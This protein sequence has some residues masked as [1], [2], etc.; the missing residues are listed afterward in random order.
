MNGAYP[1]YL[2]YRALYHRYYCGRTGDELLDLIEPINGSCVLDLCG[3]EGQ[4]TRGAIIRRARLVLLVDAEKDMV[5]EDIQAMKG[6]AVETATVHEALRRISKDRTGP[7]NRV[8]CRQAVN[9]WLDEETAKLLASVLTPG[10]IFAFNTFNQKPA[11]EPS[12]RKYQF[13]GYAFV[14]LSWLVGETVHHVQTREG[15]PPHTTTFRWISPERFREILDPYFH[16]DEKFDGKTT[17]YRCVK[18]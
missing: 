2:T 13:D 10:G 6:V 3:G 1:D 5:R 18:K 17:L 14:E 8:V 7:F 12:V 11:I 9:Y 4:L 16:V 15:L